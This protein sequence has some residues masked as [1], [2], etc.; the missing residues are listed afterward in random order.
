[1][2]CDRDHHGHHS[3]PHETTASVEKTNIKSNKYFFI[4][5]FFKI[6]N[7]CLILLN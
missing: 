4:L 5:F 7:N 2:Q 1:M 6:S 3:L